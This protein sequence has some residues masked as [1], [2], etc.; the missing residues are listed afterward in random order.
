MGGKRLDVKVHY[1]LSW[2][3][4]M[5]K[6]FYISWLT[7]VAECG[8]S[9]ICVH[10]RQKN[11]CKDCGGPG[12]CV[13]R[14]EKASCKECKGLNLCLHGSQKATCKECGNSNKCIHGKRKNQCKDCKGLLLCS[15]HGKPSH[16][17]DECALLKTSTQ[18]IV[19]INSVDLANKSTALNIASESL[20]ELAIVASLEYESVHNPGTAIKKSTESIRQAPTASTCSMDTIEHH[21]LS[22]PLPPK[23]R[24]LDN[25]TV[26]KTEFTGST[27][28]ESNSSFPSVENFTE[29]I[30]SDVASS[31]NG[32][33]SNEEGDNGEDGSSEKSLLLWE[34]R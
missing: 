18:N 19:N 8:G 28:L 20:W 34:L 25:S 9:S 4:K 2:I 11:R 3:H 12:I 26:V 6:N 33:T 5:N 30:S 22:S 13:H 14:R 17:C 16:S 32:S 15:L 7:F 23:K 29:C 31:D 1:V 24:K 10:G 27:Q 21:V